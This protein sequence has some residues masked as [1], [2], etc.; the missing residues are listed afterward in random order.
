MGLVV[1]SL[2]IL[3][4][5]LRILKVKRLEGEGMTQKQAE[6]I[7]AVVTEVLQDSLNTIAH[8]FVSREEMIKVG[9]T[10]ST[11]LFL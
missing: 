10:L 9:L 5:L 8:S 2:L 4:L 1:Y 11:L 3:F 6:A 7:T